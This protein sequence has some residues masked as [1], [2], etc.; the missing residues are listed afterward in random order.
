MQG[1]DVPAA[2]G[3]GVHPLPCA[4]IQGRRSRADKGAAEQALTFPQTLFKDTPRLGRY[5]QLTMWL[6]YRRVEKR[7]EA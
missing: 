5:I 3:A 7:S 6:D 1:R 2:P 4:H